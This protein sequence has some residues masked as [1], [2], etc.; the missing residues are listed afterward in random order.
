MSRIIL[1][2]LRPLLPEYQLKA[3]TDSEETQVSDYL[4]LFE[5][6]TSYPMVVLAETVALANQHQKSFLCLLSLSYSIKS[7]RSPQ[8]EQSFSEYEIFGIAEL[9]KDYGQVLIRP[10]TISDKISDVFIHTDVD[11][12]LDEEFSRKYYVD[13]SDEDKLRLRITPAFL[14]TYRNFNGIE[15]EISGNILM[16]RLRKQFTVE[17]GLFIAKFLAEINDGEN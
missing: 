5:S 17:N 8:S 1:D 7:R 12:D 14:R 9:R 6:M 11:F 3:A 15:A 10:E 13:A 2:N 4:L 16:A